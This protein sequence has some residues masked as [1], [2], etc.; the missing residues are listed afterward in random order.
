[1]SG[2][3]DASLKALAGVLG[4]RFRRWALL[5]EAV[6]HPGA[7]GRARLG[8]YERLEFLGDRV[9]GLVVAEHLFKIFPEESEGDLNLRYS[10]IVRREAATRVA[11][12]IDLGRYLRVSKGEADAE[13]RTNPAILADAL[14]AV[15]GAVYLDGGLEAGRAVV[16]RLWMP[17]MGNMTGPHRDA[18]TTLQEWA[19]ARGLPVPDYRTAAREGPPHAPRFTISVVVAGQ[20]PVEGAGRSK[21]AAEQAAATRMLKVLGEGHD[22]E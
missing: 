20:A 19:L 8:D 16:E 5:G 1:M 14:E 17:L 13:E 22:A 4:H 21:R 7:V 15:L 12:K 9:L 18:K 6:T 10:A 2:S 11:E 3:D